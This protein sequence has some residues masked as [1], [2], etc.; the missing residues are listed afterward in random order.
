MLQC[1]YAQTRGRG[2]GLARAQLAYD[3]YTSRQHKTKPVGKSHT[4]LSLARGIVTGR[5]KRLGFGRAFCAIEPGRSADQ[6]RSKTVLVPNAQAGELVAKGEV[7]MDLAQGLGSCC[8]SG[9]Y[10]PLTRLRRPRK[11]AAAPPV[12]V[13]P[14]QCRCPAP[15]RSSICPCRPCGGAGYAFPTRPCSCPSALHLRFVRRPSYCRGLA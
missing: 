10:L 9:I 14:F 13:G 12:R 15:C 7:E 1:S 11:G 5:P 8:R 3:R 6:M 4:T 2:S